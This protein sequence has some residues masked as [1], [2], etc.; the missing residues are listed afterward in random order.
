MTEDWNAG[1]LGRARRV[2]DALMRRIHFQD[3]HWLWRGAENFAGSPVVAVGSDVTDA[4]DAV[5]EA[6][7]P[8]RR[9]PPRRC[10]ERKCV[11]P[12]CRD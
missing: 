5:W 10:P 12:G 3:G 8:T 9:V 2:K 7:R 4:A 6:F 1:Q 11:N